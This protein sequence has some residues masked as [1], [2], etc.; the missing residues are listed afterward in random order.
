MTMP[1]CLMVVHICDIHVF[2]VVVMFAGDTDR[3][4]FSRRP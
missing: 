4:L 1:F 3:V 2:N